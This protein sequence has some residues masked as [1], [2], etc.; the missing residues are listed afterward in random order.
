MTIFGLKIGMQMLAIAGVLLLVFL[1]ITLG[2]AACNSIRSLTAQTKVDEA[3]H[4][5]LVNSA[6]DA[7]QTQGNVAAN[8][9][10]SEE[11]SRNNEQDIRHAQGANQTIDPAARDAGFA[12]LCK[13]PSFVANPANRVRCAHPSV[14]AGA[15][16]NP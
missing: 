13:R 3:Q 1:V 4:G 6:G 14:V 5:A 9:V 15:G 10:A 11:L 7:I 2:P 12:S 16:H 8:A